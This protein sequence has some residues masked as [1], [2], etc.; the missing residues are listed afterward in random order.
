LWLSAVYGLSRDPNKPSFL[1][2]LSELRAVHPGPWLITDDANLIYKVEGKNNSKV[3]RWLMGQFRQFINESS[4]KEIDQSG[5]LY[6]WNSERE[7]HAGAVRP[8]VHNQ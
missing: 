7:P 1:A 3:N 5:H 4:L 8:S 2:K 6:T